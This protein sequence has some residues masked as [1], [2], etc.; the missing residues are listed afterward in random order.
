MQVIC[1]SCQSCFLLPPGVKTGTRLRC[2]VCRHE[3]SYTGPD[4]PHEPV[5]QADASPE[6]FGMPSPAAA[7]P[8]PV[9]EQMSGQSYSD[10]SL[11]FEPASSKEVFLPKSGSGDLPVLGAK[12]KKSHAGL[13]L[14]LLILIGLAGVAAWFTVPEFRSCLMQYKDSFF[15]EDSAKPA[16]DTN[17]KAESAAAAPQQDQ[18][19]AV[20]T[21]TLIFENTGNRYVDNDHTGKL[22]IIEGR[23]KN[24]GDTAMGNIMLHAALL[25]KDRKV[26]DKAEQV[27]GHVLT[28]FQLKVMTRAEM[29]KALDE[30]AQGGSGV[31]AKDGTVPFMIIFCNPSD[32]LSEFSVKIGKADKVADTA[33][34]QS[35]AAAP[36]A[37][38]EPVQPAAP[39]PDAQQMP[40]P[41]LPD[42]AAAPQ[43]PSAAQPQSVPQTVPQSMPQSV[44]PAVQPTAQ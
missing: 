3:F 31:A 5:Q 23:V 12:E 24:T 19:A 28:D 16:P 39:L 25:D 26:I 32:D 35:G 38:A 44:P 42:P 20:R 1:P 14:G 22:L 4:V 15:A 30:E 34:A 36:A 6:S 21:D 37:P 9:Q 29:I 8:Q 43:A 41:S 40:A 7:K 17:A 10:Q 11:N 27:A 2:S 13:W 18:P 33:P